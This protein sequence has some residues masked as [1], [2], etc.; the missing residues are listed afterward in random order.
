MIRRTLG[1]R[2]PLE[3][4]SANSPTHR[5]YTK[6]RGLEKRRRSTRGSGRGLH[7]RTAMVDAYRIGH[8]TARRVLKALD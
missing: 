5:T 8:I 3:L 7:F 6:L 1:E 4:I 2:T